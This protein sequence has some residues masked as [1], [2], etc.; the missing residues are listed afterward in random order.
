MKRRKFLQGA[1]TLGAAVLLPAAAHAAADAFAA[2]A[3]SRF[4]LLRS[5]GGPGAR[6]FPHAA[7]SAADCGADTLRLRIDG[8]QRADGAPVLHELWL[9]ALFDHPDGGT[10]PF[11]AW[12]FTD[13]PR[14]STGQR[15]AF[16]APRAGMRGF[17]LDYRLGAAAA[18]TR[19]TC[20]LT[21]L[22]LP[23]LT[24]GH[25]ALLGPRRDGGPA[26]P[27]G[28]THSGNL[29]APLAAGVSRDFDCLAF[30]IEAV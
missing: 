26:S 5:S 29:A 13:G 17:A 12:Q 20:A 6:F 2:P 23:L 9:S 27:H 19:E 28:L 21:S 4:T 16:V 7:C 14:A 22:G 24:P 8:L 25:Y 18:C 10:A 30:R 3:Q 11:L 15:I 1:G